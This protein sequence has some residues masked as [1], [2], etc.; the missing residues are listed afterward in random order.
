MKTMKNIMISALLALAALGLTF[1]LSAYAD[2]MSD[3]NLYCSG[4]HNGLV[5]NG[6]I[7]G[8]GA[9]SCPDRGYQGWMDTINRMNGKGCGV[10]SEGVNSFV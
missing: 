8:G 9:K 7:I 6:T 1:S 2:G 10:P 5:V 4:C 3:V